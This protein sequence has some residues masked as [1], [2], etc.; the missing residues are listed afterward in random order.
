MECRW[1]SL[2]RC[3]KSRPAFRRN[4]PSNRSAYRSACSRARFRR[5][6]CQVNTA[7]ETARAPDKQGKSLAE[8][9]SVNLPR[10]ALSDPEGGGAGIGLPDLSP[11]FM[12]AGRPVRDDADQLNNIIGDLARCYRCGAVRST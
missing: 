10:G 8:A 4:E 2:A 11:R 7:A 9:L 1:L 12:T 3:R 6:G 5:R